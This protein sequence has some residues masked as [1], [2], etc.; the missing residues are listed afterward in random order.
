MSLVRD[1]DGAPLHYIVQLQD[2][3][4]RKELEQQLR[5][6]SDHDEITGL[7]NRRL[8][9]YDLQLQIARSRRYDEVAG[10]L[11]V[12]LDDFGRIDDA[13]GL[14]ACEEMLRAVAR[15][16]TRRLRQ[17]DL[18]ARLRAATSSRCCSRTWT[19]RALARRSRRPRAGGRGVPCGPRRRA[20]SAR[21]RASA[22]C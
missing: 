10:L 1:I 20:S 7:R 6:L 22:R 9:E 2:I 13:Y 4:E 18:I 3:S 16:L 5:G 14:G 21:A 17:T 8:F 12:D 15:A 11:V 19:T